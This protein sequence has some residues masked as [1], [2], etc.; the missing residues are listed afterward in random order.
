MLLA[1]NK[2]ADNRMDFN[3]ISSRNSALTQ[4]YSAKIS[5]GLISSTTF[6]PSTDLE[7]SMRCLVL[8]ATY[9]GQAYLRD[10]IDSILRQTGVDVHILIT[11]DCSSD[12]SYEIASEYASRDSRVY[13][14]RN[15]N[16]KGVANNFMSMIASIDPNSFDYVAFS[17]QDDVWLKDK[18]VTAVKAI[19]DKCSSTDAKKL[20]GIGTPTLYCSD[21]QNVNEHLG[22]SQLEL[23]RLNIDL[24]HRATPLLKN[25]FSGCTMVMNA[26]MVRL[27]QEYK[28]EEFPRIH[29]VWCSMVAYYCGNLVYDADHALILRRITGNNTNGA[30]TAGKDIHEA[31][32]K[33]LAHASMRNISKSADLLYKT[34]SWAMSENDSALVGSFASYRNS[35]I[36]RLK[37]VFSPDYKAVTFG[38]T[39]LLRTKILLGRL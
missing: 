20:S 7:G 6:V 34:Y 11:D 38:E 10:Q 9:N 5:S 23:K 25:Y 29:D 4:K 13:S 30:I 2:I 37:W 32:L 35:I 14:R 22:E 26:A 31:S 21:L 19:N 24:G 8:M 16:N 12:N 33:H 39:M 1:A 27:L 17:D 18:L 36:S 15:S 28:G 3:K